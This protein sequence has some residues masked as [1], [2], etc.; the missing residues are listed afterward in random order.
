MNDDKVRALAIMVSQVIADDHKHVQLFIEAISHGMTER[1][2]KLAER[3]NCLESFAMLLAS[4]TNPAVSMANN[5]LENPA[6]SE[7]FKTRVS[8]LLTTRNTQ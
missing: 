8:H 1:C 5:L 3:S 4:G 7:F 2:D 6:F